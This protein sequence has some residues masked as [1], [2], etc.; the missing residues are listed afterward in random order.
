MKVTVNKQMVASKL[1]IEGD[2]QKLH[3]SSRRKEKLKKSHW[4]SSKFRMIAEKY[5]I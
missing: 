2:A 5:V 1:Y 3:W 4:L